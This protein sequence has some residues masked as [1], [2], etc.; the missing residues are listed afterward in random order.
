MRSGTELTAGRLLVLLAITG[1]MVG[2]SLLA[3]WYG[4]F[5]R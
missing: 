3:V 1:F 5:V 2:A 4:A